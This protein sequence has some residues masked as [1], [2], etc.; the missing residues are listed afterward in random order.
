MPQ[1][2]STLTEAIELVA[3]GSWAIDSALRCIDDDDAERAR[4]VLVGAQDS[5]RDGL[6]GLRTVLEST[7]RE[8]YERPEQLARAVASLQELAELSPSPED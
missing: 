5:I 4:T 2:V 8:A 3:A 1:D 7:V 6:E